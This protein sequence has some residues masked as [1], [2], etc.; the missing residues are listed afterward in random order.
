MPYRVR[1]EGPL[2]CVLS[3][4]FDSFLAAHAYARENQKKIPAAIM[5]IVELDEC[6]RETN[7]REFVKL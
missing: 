6:G 2:G 3:D 7:N 5:V 1:F 4:H